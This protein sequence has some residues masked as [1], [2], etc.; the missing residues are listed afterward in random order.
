MAGMRDRVSHEYFGVDLRKVWLVVKEE[1]PRL[2]PLVGKALE[3][4]GSQ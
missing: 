3:E 1:I 4:L 2:K